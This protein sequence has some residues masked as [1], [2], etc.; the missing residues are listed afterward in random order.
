[1]AIATKLL[2]AQK[3]VAE[4][5]K[6]AKNSHHGYSYGTSD[7]IIA[8]GKIALNDCGLVLLNDSWNVNVDKMCI[9]GTFLLLEAEGDDKLSLNAE[10]PFVPGNGRPNDK[11][12][13]ASLT[14]MRGYLTLGLLQ[15]ERIEGVDVSG[16]DD[17]KWAD[18]SPQRPQQQQ[19]GPQQQ[20]NGNDNDGD[21][22]TCKGCNGPMRMG[23][24]GKPYCHPCYVDWKE[25][26]NASAGNRRDY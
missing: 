26:Q 8:L 1:M 10:L 14:E 20:H 3:I 9:S 2:A 19:P 5:T 25:R 6:D 24:N 13:L 23:R 12:V 4:A 18:D 11:A 16:R 21:L 7:S 17:T 22:G 15:I